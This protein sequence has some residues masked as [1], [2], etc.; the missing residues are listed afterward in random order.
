MIFLFL[1]VEE[2]YSTRYQSGSFS[3]LIVG[4]NFHCVFSFQQQSSVATA[5]NP[6]TH[7]NFVVCVCTV[8]GGLPNWCGHLRNPLP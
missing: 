3:L 4:S 8:R 7:T 5:H 6:L 2:L 1:L